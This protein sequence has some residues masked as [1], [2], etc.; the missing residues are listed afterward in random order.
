MFVL[1]CVCLC[2]FSLSCLLPPRF[3]FI[4]RY[5]VTWEVTGG[6][7]LFCDNWARFC[8]LMA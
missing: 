5:Y 3:P 7:V 6:F 2:P 1:L 8:S 4:G